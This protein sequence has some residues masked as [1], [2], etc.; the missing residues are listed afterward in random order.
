MGSKLC[1]KKVKSQKRRKK[2]CF[3]QKPEKR[4]KKCDF[5]ENL[6]EESQKSFFRTFLGGPKMD[7]FLDHFL[8]QKW[9]TFLGGKTAFLGLKVVD[10]K[11]PF[12]GVSF[13]AIFWS[14]FGPP[15]KSN[16]PHTYGGGC[17][18]PARQKRGLDIHVDVFG[19]VISKMAKMA[20][21]EKTL[22]LTIF[23]FFPCFWKPKPVRNH[24][25]WIIYSP[26]DVWDP[27]VG[28]KWPKNGP[29]MTC[30]RVLDRIAIL[31]KSWFSRKTGN[32][33]LFGQKWWKSWKSRFLSR[34]Y[35]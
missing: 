8:L 32:F 29:K 15:K 12:L 25:K 19:P 4:W 22:F 26:L 23:V 27:G 17:F 34:Y 18:W 11:W 13:L 9:V 2:R 20:K 10:Q 24:K 16:P 7:P 3:W 33:S 31:T 28:Q 30:F 5:W 14:G 35:S 1:P 6:V 21:T